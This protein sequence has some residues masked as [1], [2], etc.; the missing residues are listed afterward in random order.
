MIALYPRVSTQE[1]ALN[2]HS[3]DEQIERMEK[4]CE[5]MGWS[6]I[7]IYT[8]AGFSG[9]N[10]DRPALSRMINDIRQGKIKKV[11][12]YKLD[13]LSRSQKDTL[14]LIED[15]FLAN[16]CDFVSMSENFDT[17]T[18]FGRAMIGILAVF[19]QLEREQIK[20]RMSMGKDA[21][22][23][24][25]VWHGGICP[26]GYTYQ[27][28]KLIVS[29]FEAMQVR[30]LFKLYLDG[31][32]LRAIAREF[33]KKGYTATDQKN[34]R[35][36]IA[37]RIY[38][39]YIKHKDQWIKGQHEPIIDEATFFEANRILEKSKQEFEQLGIKTGIHAQSTLL[40]GLLWCSQ[41][42]A[43]YGK[44]QSG[45]KKNVIYKNYACYSRHKKVKSMIKNP[46]CKNK[47]Y[48][49]SD[50]DSIII[51]EI[52]KLSVD[53]EC[54]SENTPDTDKTQKI[55]LMQ[56]EINSIDDQISRLLDLYSLGRFSVDQLDRKVVAL[57]DLREKM[58]QEIENLQT[59]DTKMPRHEAMEIIRSFEDILKRNNFDEMKQVVDALIEKI[60]ID[61][62]DI[63]IYWNFT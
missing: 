36:I 29:D 28:G 3:I 63:T 42:G 43:R 32:P 33:A 52:M 18:P 54:L 44:C 48:R 6:P 56:K 25:G 24:T 41:C 21:R 59:P 39:G 15:V 17:S 35:R 62:D 31:M 57:Q 47:T 11:L 20:E 8:D 60:M 45:K 53:S 30:E 22:A 34:Y 37:N 13:R 16:G 23:K 26:F 9:A 19:A 38:I 46:E 55:N 2:G 27:N 10:T 58:Q 40:G 4:Y 61:N 51:N 50:L 49:I 12:V 1:Q 7:K 14:M 5:S